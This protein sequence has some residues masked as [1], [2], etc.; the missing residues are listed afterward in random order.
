VLS[1]IIDHDFTPFIAVHDPLIIGFGINGDGIDKVT[2]QTY[3]SGIHVHCT[4]S[5]DPSI[6]ATDWFFANGSKVGLSDL[7]FREGHYNNGTTVLQIGVGRALT[8]CDGGNYTCV[9]NTTSGRT[10]RR[11]FHLLIRSMLILNLLYKRDHLGALNKH[12]MYSLQI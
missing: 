6:T 3:N 2:K 1:I 7:N 10:E 12:A 9:V 4:V 11:S 5:S 8:Y